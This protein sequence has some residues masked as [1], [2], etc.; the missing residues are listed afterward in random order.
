MAAVTE[1]A[2]PAGTVALPT[3]ATVVVVVAAAAVEVAV[4]KA[5]PL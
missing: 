4:T 5:T 2:D 3:A 1:A